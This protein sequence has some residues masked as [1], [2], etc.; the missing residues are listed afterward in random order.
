MFEHENSRN[1]RTGSQG[2]PS[3]S[4][5]LA[6]YRKNDKTYLAIP[7]SKEVIYTI[8]N[9]WLANG[10]IGLP[11]PRK[12]ATE[13]EKFHPHYCRYHQYIGHSTIACQKLRKIYYEGASG[14]L[15]GSL[16]QSRTKGI[17]SPQYEERDMS[18]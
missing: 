2:M 13:N 12:L 7:H 15:F 11:R 4:Q 6:S 10:I 1:N 14:G 8:V 16:P 18:Q 17:F 3:S 9:Y 5:V